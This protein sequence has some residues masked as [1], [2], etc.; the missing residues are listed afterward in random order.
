MPYTDRLARFNITAV[1]NGEIS[2]NTVWM[3]NDSPAFGLGGNLE[4]MTK[5]VRDEWSKLVL[6]GVGLAAGIAPHLWVGAEYNAV[7]GYR[8]DALG[9]ATEQYNAAFAPGV[10]GTSANVLPLHNALVISLQTK[11]PGRSGRGRLF[12]GPIGAGVLASNGRVTP[13]VRDAIALAFAGFYTRL[14]DLPAADDKF[15]PV[16]ASRTKTDAYPITALNV[17]DY[18]DTMRSRRSALV[19][20]RVSQVVDAS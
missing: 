19:E 10:K 11:Q 3:R 7:N 1:I 2:V 13:A 14:R 18:I 16:V 17:G 6:G 12:L 4:A 9:K 20:N 15:R 8:V 5:K